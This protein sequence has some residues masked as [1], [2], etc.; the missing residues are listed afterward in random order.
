MAS[1]IL[2]WDAIFCRWYMTEARCCCIEENLD[3]IMATVLFI[4][5]KPVIAPAMIVDNLLALNDGVAIN[6][7]R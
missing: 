4:S 5:E 7:G 2:I 6:T 3:G 1:Q